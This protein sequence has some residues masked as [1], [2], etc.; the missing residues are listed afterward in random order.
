VAGYV[1]MRLTGAS[2]GPPKTITASVDCTQSGP[3]PPGGTGGFYGYKSTT[4]YLVQ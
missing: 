2:S 3:Q 1:E 4:V